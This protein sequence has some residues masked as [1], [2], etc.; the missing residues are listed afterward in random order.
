MHLYRNLF[1]ITSI[2]VIFLG[3]ANCIFSLDHS[4]RMLFE[5][6]GTT[7]LI[8]H[9]D[10][11]QQKFNLGF[12]HCVGV[13]VY[14]FLLLFIL[15]KYENCYFINVNVNKSE[16]VDM[17]VSQESCLIKKS[18]NLLYIVIYAMRNEMKLSLLFKT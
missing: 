13:L 1:N 3:T 10:N 16:T 2:T 17:A 6:F 14:T 9:S 5:M 7:F 4:T 11:I 8:L 12:S 15:R 18:L